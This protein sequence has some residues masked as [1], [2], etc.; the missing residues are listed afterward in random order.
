MQL[1]CLPSE[2]MFDAEEATLLAFSAVQACG[3]TKMQTHFNRLLFSYLEFK[4]H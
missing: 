3:G 4:S 2:L 1:S